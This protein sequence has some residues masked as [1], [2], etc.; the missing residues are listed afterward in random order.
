MTSK[1]WELLKN[2]ELFR[3]SADSENNIWVMT[4]SDLYKYLTASQELVHLVNYSVPNPINGGYEGELVEDSEGNMYAVHINLPY[5][6]KFP[7]SFQ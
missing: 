7:K 1:N 5:P 2:K 6:I 4:T 3:I